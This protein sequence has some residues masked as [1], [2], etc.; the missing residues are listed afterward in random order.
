[1]SRRFVSELSARVNA[2]QRG[3]TST[4]SLVVASLLA[5][6]ERRLQFDRHTE[7]VTE[8]LEL[9][10]WLYD[11]PP[12]TMVGGK[13]FARACNADLESGIDRLKALRATYG[14]FR[15]KPNK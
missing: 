8:Y 11:G 15:K 6:A 2:S 7:L 10:D 12:T 9:W 13:P 3:G 14:T 5:E 1:M 4:R